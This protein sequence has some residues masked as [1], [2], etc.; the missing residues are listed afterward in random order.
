LI[1]GEM[2]TNGQLGCG[3]NDILALD[4]PAARPAVGT[5]DWRNWRL[6]QWN[7]HLLAHFF[8]RRSDGDLP[9]VALLATPE[10]LARATGDRSADPS[11][12]RDVFVGSVREA[13]ASSESLLDDA[14]NYQSWPDSPPLDRV[15]RFISHLIFTC[16]AASESSEALASE[17]SYLQ[18]LRD[19]AE[20]ALPDH[21]L[22]WLPTLW[23][24]LAAWLAANARG[25]RPLKLPDP[26]GYTRIGYTVK[27]TFPDRR[28]QRALSELL[29]RANLLGNEPPIGKVIALVASERAQFRDS[30]LEAF[31]D[32]RR[33]LAR[34]SL[35]TRDVVEHRFW[36]AVRDAALRGRGAAE[37][38]VP[39]MSVRFQLL[40]EEQ[41]DRLYPFVVADAPL[42]SVGLTSMELPV[43]FDVWRYAV[44]AG[45]TASID[46]EAAYV[47]ARAVLQGSLSI[48]RLSSL[49]AQ[50]LVPLA[51]GVHGYLELAG[52][53]Q[54]EESRT[55]LARQGLVQDLIEIFGKG[56]ARSRSST[57]EG[58]IEI[59][60]LQ[61]RRLPSE[62]LERTTLSNCW[63][64][65]ESVAPIVV[66]LQGG[67]RA[68]D[69]WLGYREVLPRVMSPGALE[70][71][72]RRPDGKTEPLQADEEGAWRLPYLDHEGEYEITAAME[73]GSIERVTVRF[74]R[75]IG[76]EAFRV[77]DE[78]DAW[79][80][81]GLGGTGTLSML[82][83][84]T[85]SQNDAIAPVPD[86]TVYLGPIVGQ[87]VGCPQEAAWRVTSFAGRTS[88]ARSRCDLGAITGLARLAD[89]STRRKWRKLLLNCRADASDEGFLA[90]RSRIRQRVMSGQLPIVDAAS[91]ILAVEPV[92][93]GSVAPEVERLLSIAAARAGS[94]TGITYREWSKHVETVMGLPRDGIRAI[95]RSWAEAGLLDIAFYAR[96]THCSVF[97]RAPRL[98]AFQTLGGFG[99]TIMGM[100]LP[101]TR[102]G[103]ISA[104]KQAGV[105]I[106]HRCGVSPLTP[107][108]LTMRG[109]RLEH[110]VDLS[111]QTGIPL[112]WLDLDTE[113]YA[114]QCRH[115]GRD[116]PPQNYEDRVRWTRW[117]LGRL[118][119]E[120]G[121][122]FE[123][124]TRLGRPDYW[125][126]SYQGRSAW[127]YDVNT[128]RLWAAAMLQ[129]QPLVVS[130]DTG[131]RVVHAFLPLP[132]A[133]FLSVV[134]GA[135][136]GLD[137]NGQYHY[138]V[139]AQELRDRL[140]GI[141]ETIFDVRRLSPREQP[142]MG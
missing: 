92:Q 131:L 8:G 86:R 41:D 16:I 42:T 38:V 79:I 94:R 84:L 47:T 52:Y 56:R 43:A 124:W 98:V 62:M 88:G 120:T 23:A 55:V 78:L 130:G 129:E 132:L 61:L 36:S 2:S 111:K 34:G 40:C 17:G 70:V 135:A 112:S 77:P 89:Y 14:S 49:A 82:A 113:H 67:V 35:H 140:L 1:A 20:G 104:A 58:W 128:A 53:E 117:S 127:S 125:C 76:T 22:Q 12:V 106:E 138:R 25:Y 123:H 46:P 57:I 63:Q 87:F 139:G 83:P 116:L 21:S 27:L 122:L 51:D 119:G 114:E 105:E 126:V 45:E 44:V 97:A 141:V 133:R 110:L 90:A 48:P 18:R 13:I 29:G 4:R 81:E 19:L 108:L 74:N 142:R 28:D 107:A 95:T 24:N 71:H 69:G 91:R 100:L 9:V 33:C 26:G 118:E 3:V 103:L 39:E 32:F 102:R 134:Q 6:Q 121:I 5:S 11:E 73:D 72:Q 96:W 50:G 31:D 80:A 75:V 99:A 60:G 68:D 64:V 10:E 59:R 85:S 136:P 109:G 37:E 66:R 30:F 115:D 137:Q 54:L 93:S 15:P 65:H 101:T 7:E